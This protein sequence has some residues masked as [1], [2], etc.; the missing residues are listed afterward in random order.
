MISL[1][2]SCV[3]QWVCSHRVRV[4]PYTTFSDL[5]FIH[6]HPWKSSFCRGTS[7]GEGQGCI[8][9]PAGAA[10]LPNLPSILISRRVIVLSPLRLALRVLIQFV[11]D[12]RNLYFYQLTSLPLNVEKKINPCTKLT[13]VIKMLYV[14]TLKFSPCTF[15]FLN[16]FKKKENAK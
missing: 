9:R 8:V 1:R 13:P 2:N 14:G 5:F 15:F 11:L 12:F 10:R 7:G 6:F 3:F 4:S 16:L